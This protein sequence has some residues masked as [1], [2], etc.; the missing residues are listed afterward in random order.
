M[1]WE[2]ERCGNRSAD[3]VAACPSCGH[4]KEAWS[5]VQDVTRALVLQV[6]RLEVLRGTDARTLPADHPAQAAHALEPAEVAPVLPRSRA[7]TL[8]SCGHLP[9]SEHVL[10]VRVT[11][12]S[13]KDRVLT[14]GVDHAAAAAQEHTLPLA[15]ADLDEQERF[16]VRLLLVAGEGP[17]AEELRFPG[18]HVVDVSE[19][20]GPGHATGV[21]VSAVRK[22]PVELPTRLVDEPRRVLA[23]GALPGVTFAHGSSFVRPA[24][25][26]HLRE[27]EALAAAH[28][29]SRVL[30]FGH[31]DATGDE[32][33]NKKLS[34]R[35]A[36]SVFAFLTDDATAWEALYQHDDEGWGLGVLQEILA[37]L[38]HDP[39]PPDGDPGPLTDAALRSFRGLSEDAPAPANDAALRRDLFSAYMTN[40]RRD[41]DLPRERFVAPGYMGCG[42]LNLLEQTSGA[43]EQNRRVSFFFVHPDAVPA[44]PC[45]FADVTP[46]HAQAHAPGERKLASF[47]CAFYDALAADCPCDETERELIELRLY[48][49]DHACIPYAPFRISVDGAVV[50]VGAANK[51]GY[52]RRLDLPV[53]GRCLLEWSSPGQDAFE[54]QRELYLEPAAAT[55]EQR[56][57]HLGYS[58]ALPLDQRVSRFQQDYG[59]A[60]TG[61]LDP[62]TVDAIRRTHDEAAPVLGQEQ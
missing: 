14:L 49:R 23:C 45:K 5:V 8:A 52:V 41:I 32:L 58:D 16:L 57:H 34:E 12:G 59:L 22:G 46:C 24:V 21:Q 40:A 2:C 30:V 11:P 6:S 37:D 55:D 13:A 7:A 9:A 28:P 19:P 29:G 3:D 35:R 50:A 44:L 53:G 27:L 18:L 36:W 31:A 62:P 56:L 17:P 43:S 54:H 1:P 26:P 61:D 47:R 42:E 60:V 33:Y 20:G 25:V 15:D 4:E 48:D 39:G 10:H 38:G 51:H